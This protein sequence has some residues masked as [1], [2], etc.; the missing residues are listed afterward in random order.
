M[1]DKPFRC[2]LGFHSY[3]REHPRDERLSGQSGDVC[4]LCGKHRRPS[5]IPPAVLGS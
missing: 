5:G 1:A 4:R 2:L 3:V